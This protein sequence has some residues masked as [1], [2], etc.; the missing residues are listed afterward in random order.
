MVR[1]STAS[2]HGLERCYLKDSGRA[3][4]VSVTDDEAVEG[5]NLLSRTEGI[6]P[7]L[8][9]AHAIAYAVKLAKKMKEDE[10]IVVT[11]SGRGDK[12]VQLIA[13]RA[14]IAI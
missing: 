6:L 4:Y 7:A 5:F 8:E 14:G 1:I 13:K 11:L 9:S 10:N 12:D 3:T 2:I